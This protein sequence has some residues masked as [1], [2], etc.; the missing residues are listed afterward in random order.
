MGAGEIV[1]ALSNPTE[2]KIFA[3]RLSD[4]ISANFDANER[5]GGRKYYV[6]LVIKVCGLLLRVHNILDLF[7]AVV[8]V[9]LNEG[10][11]HVWGE[12]GEHPYQE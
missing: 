1:E 11:R 4:L 6:S 3:A 8:V 2:A 7:F 9:S 5:V 10:R 12:R